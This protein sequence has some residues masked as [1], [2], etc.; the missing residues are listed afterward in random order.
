MEELYTEASHDLGLLAS[1]VDRAAR[2]EV[3]AFEYHPLGFVHIDLSDVNDLSS[4]ALHYW[5]NTRYTQIHNHYF[6]LSSTV[7]VGC[8][9]DVWIDVSRSQDGEYQLY[10]IEYDHLSA[11]RKI[12]R[13]SAEHRHHVAVER[14]VQHSAGSQYSV[15]KHQFHKSRFVNSHS[16]FAITLMLRSNC[17]SLFERKSF[18]LSKEDYAESAITERSL[19]HQRKLVVS[20]QIRTSL[21]GAGIA[22]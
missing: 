6:D 20:K 16:E 13:F 15:P 11:V 18:T 10:S 19:D 3:G 9:E 21:R 14:S 12:Q 22:S 1:L 7:I 8:I 4:I 5:T 2:T 17:G